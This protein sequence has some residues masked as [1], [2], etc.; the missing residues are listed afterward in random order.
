M[1]EELPPPRLLAG[2]EQDV[3][4]RELL[5][6]DLDEE[7]RLLAGAAA[8]GAEGARV[9]R[10]A[11]R[12]AAARGRTRAR[13]RRTWRAGPASRPCGVGR[14]RAVLGAV[15]GGHAAAGRGRQRPGRRARPRWTPPSWSPPRCSRSRRRRAARARAGPGAA[16]ARRR[17]PAPR[18]AADQLVR[19]L[20]HTA[21]EFVV[22]GDPDQAC[23]PSAAPTRAC[24]PTPT[25][26]QPDRHAARRPPAGP[27]VRPAV[28][29]IGATLP[30]LSQ[31]RKSSRPRGLPAGT[32]G[33]ACWRR[34]RRR[35]AGSPTSSA[36]RTSSTACRGRRW[37]CCVRSPARTFRCCG[38][39]CWPPGCR[40]ALRPR[41]CRWR[42]SPRCGRCWPCCAR[43]RG[44]PARR[45]PRRV[46]LSSPLGGADPLALRRLRRGLRRLELAGGGERSSGELL[47]EVL[48][49]GG[50]PGRA[51]RRRGG[52]CA[53]SARCCAHAPGRGARRG[54]E[55]VLWQL[56]KDS[57]LRTSAGAQATAGGPPG[58]Q[59]DRD[60]DAVVA[61]STRPPATSTGCR[62]RASRPSRITW[63]N[64]S[65]VTRWP[66]PPA[67]DGRHVLTAHA[68]AGRE[69]TV[70]AVPGV[71]EGP[72]RTC[73]C[74]APCWAWNG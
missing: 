18:P 19:V 27:A 62:A 72:G 35:P 38:G 42:G 21:A 74:A 2:P 7:A 67:G 47:V 34:R 30:G 11:A 73:G 56:W 43:A 60:L 37:R 44:R 36:A 33:S 22:A 51:G 4:V 32:C 9:R 70:V 24:S 23:S 16:P 53:A 17:R 3:V 65:P 71:Q 20:G 55:Q 63:H 10:G 41:S 12:P 59:A 48:R 69:W 15:R 50:H 26:R 61:C 5:A 58:A 25:R 6:G 52:R 66:R 49:G 13:A 64:R 46:L 31:H 39:P 29:K 54:V 68:A 8:P 1:A 28:A 40:S 45:R 14:R 57:R